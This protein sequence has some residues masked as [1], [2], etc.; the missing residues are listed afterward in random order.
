MPKLR[1]EP[2]LTDPDAFYELLTDAHRERTPEASERINAR[3]VLLLA[4]HVGDLE[5]LR[6]AVAIATGA[7]AGGTAQAGGR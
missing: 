3:L 2:N 7:D 1:L 4:N 5:V 6:E